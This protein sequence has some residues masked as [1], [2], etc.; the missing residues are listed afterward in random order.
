[1][2]KQ[3]TSRSDEVQVPS[4]VPSHASNKRASRYKARGGARRHSV[5]TICH[6]FSMRA[7]KMYFLAIPNH[8]RYFGGVATER[9]VRTDVN[10]RWWALQR[11]EVLVIVLPLNI[12]HHLQ[13]LVVNI[14]AT[15]ITMRRRRIIRMIML[16]NIGDYDSDRLVKIR[17]MTMMKRVENDLHFCT[18]PYRTFY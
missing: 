17:T 7:N 3:S 11:E 4:Q 18:I 13:L 9:W 12:K 10:A 6:K 8:L 15:N 2:C 14:L 5:S 16:P 1:M